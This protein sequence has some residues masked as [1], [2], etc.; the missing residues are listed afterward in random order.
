M[1]SLQGETGSSTV[2]LPFPKDEGGIKLS[3][4]LGYQEDDDDSEVTIPAGQDSA[5]PQAATSSSWN[6]VEAMGPE[7]L[8]EVYRQWSRGLLT[9]EGVAREH[10]PMILEALQTEH[11]L[12]MP[13]D[14]GGS[15]HA[16]PLASTYID[17][18]AND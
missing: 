18:G 4:K 1:V 10:G 15:E 16:G 12:Y 11:L 17:E 5:V 8:H 3:L 14:D 9:Y 13:G 2:R 7:M 6:S